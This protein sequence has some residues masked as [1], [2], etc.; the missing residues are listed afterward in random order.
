VLSTKLLFEIL[1]SFPHVFLINLKN[2]V[3]GTKNY[4]ISTHT[5]S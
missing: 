1:V 4:K 5:L 3:S 2:D